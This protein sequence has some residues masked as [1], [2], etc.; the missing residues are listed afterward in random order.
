MDSSD[1]YGLKFHHLGL[2]V[3]QVE[4]AVRM[5]KGL[6][7]KIGPSVR[8]DLQNVNL[9]LCTRP[10]APAIEIIYATETPGPLAA[11]LK[12]NT[13]LMYH[14]CYKSENL[15]ESLAEMRNDQNMVRVISP[16]KPA[17]LFGGRLVSFYQIRG[18]G[19][20]EILES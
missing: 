5:L 9:A 15:E 7:Y 8:D 11:I 19:M 1:T 6:G 17:V 13:S 10:E 4:N 3:K 14:T 2:A 20:I 16:P 18:F 12:L